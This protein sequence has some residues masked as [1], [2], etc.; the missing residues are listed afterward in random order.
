MA[1]GSNVTIDEITDRVG[2]DRSASSCRKEWI[3]ADGTGF[4]KP[5]FEHSDGVRCERCAALLAAFAIAAD[6]GAGA[7]HDVSAAQLGQ[8][9]DS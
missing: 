7:E 2:G 3:V 8:F 5:H 1:G 6:V 9:R 4:G